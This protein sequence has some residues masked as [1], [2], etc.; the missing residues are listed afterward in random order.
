MSSL[1]SINADQRLY[2]LACGSGYS[3]L[4]FDVADRKGRAVA[5]WAMFTW[6]EDVTPG[7]PEHYGAYLAAMK[8]GSDFALLTGRRCM[9]DTVP[10]LERWNGWRV[11]VTYPNGDKRRFNVGRSMGWMPCTLEIHNARSHGG[12]GAYFP[13]GSTVTPIRRVR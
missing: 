12:P 10:E 4:G 3:C 13:P 6:P 8:A 5:A 2:V 9:A 1:H 7:T 11:E